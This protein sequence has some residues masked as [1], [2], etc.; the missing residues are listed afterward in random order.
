MRRSIDMDDASRYRYL[1]AKIASEYRNP[2]NI[3][4]D[5]VFDDIV[6]FIVG[7]EL[8]VNKSLNQIIDDDINGIRE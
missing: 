2:K 6:N 3:N 4:D 8:G 7:T 1:L 5:S